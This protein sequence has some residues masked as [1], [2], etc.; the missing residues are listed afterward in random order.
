MFFFGL[1]AFV[2]YRSCLEVFL[3]TYAT[4]KFGMNLESAAQLLALLQVAGILG[5]PLFGKLSDA[6]GRRTMLAFLIVCQSAI[7]YLITYASLEVLVI[8][9]GAMELVAFGAIAVS[10]T[11]V[12]EM[13]AR[14]IIGTL[15]GVAL[16]ANFLSKALAS[17]IIGFFADQFGFDFSFRI[18][19]LVNLLALPILAIIKYDGRVDNSNL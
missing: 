17:P 9:L 13:K 1:V 18:I 15:V 10:D 11:F 3:A 2:S 12:T 16:T 19:F 7:M 5:A 8:L 14:D 4:E 6:T